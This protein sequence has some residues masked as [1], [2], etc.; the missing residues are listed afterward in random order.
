MPGIRPCNK[1]GN[2]KILGQYR[3]ILSA[4]AAGAVLKPSGG[5]YAVLPY[6]FSTSYSLN[7]TLTLALAASTVVE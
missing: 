2:R 1:V 5:N 7:V 4:A 6:A 3:I